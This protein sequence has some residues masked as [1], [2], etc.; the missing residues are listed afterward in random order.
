M[1]EVD[2]TGG[3]GMGKQREEVMKVWCFLI[4]AVRRR[5][6]VLLENVSV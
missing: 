5:S 1:S 6:F 3:P 4:K 2:H